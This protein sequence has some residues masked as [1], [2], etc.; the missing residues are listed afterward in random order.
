MPCK[1]RYRSFYLSPKSSTS[2]IQGCKGKGLSATSVL[3]AVV[4]AT[5]FNL[6]PPSVEALTCIIPIS[7]RPWVKLPQNIA[8]SA[9][10][11]YFDAFKSQLLRSS[12]QEDDSRWAEIWQMASAVSQSINAHRTNNLSP[13]GE[14]YTAIAALKTLPD[15]SLLFTSSI[16]KHRDAA[17]E[18]SNLGAFVH[19]NTAQPESLWHVGRMTFSRSSVISGSAVTIN[20]IT[21]GDG[22]LSIGFSWQDG[23]VE[24]KVVSGLYAGVLAYFEQYK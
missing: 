17:L 5:L 1:S 8:Q 23:V 24:D 19:S 13:S 7:L 15:V 12:I 11:N 4:S 22:G 10:G 16:G 20:V 14:P 9:I 3:T 2:F 18:V 6:L 21:G